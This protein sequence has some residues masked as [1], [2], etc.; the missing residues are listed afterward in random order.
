[1]IDL[2]NGGGASST[3]VGSGSGSGAADAGVA[4]LCGGVVFL[5]FAACSARAA[6]RAGSFLFF[7]IAAASR[8]G[9][10]TLTSVRHKFIGVEERMLDRTNCRDSGRAGRKDSW[11][12]TERWAMVLVEEMVGAWDDCPQA[13][14][15]VANAAGRI[16]ETQKE[17]GPSAVGLDAL[18]VAS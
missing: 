4:D 16:D 13:C 5:L 10:A 15:K 12:S 1:M 3:G 7:S 14:C 11:N 18:A 6:A 2:G 9:C 17:D 8:T